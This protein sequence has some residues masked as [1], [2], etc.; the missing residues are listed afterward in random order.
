MVRLRS[1]LLLRVVVR[2]RLHVA[3]IHRPSW[4]VLLIL[5][6]I[7]PPSHILLHILLPCR[8]MTTVHHAGLGKCF[9]TDR[10]L[11]R[12]GSCALRF[13]D[14]AGSQRGLVSGGQSINSSKNKLMNPVTGIVEGLTVAVVGFAVS[15]EQSVVV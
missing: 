12:V 8:Q 7:S 1:E 15:H 13:A 10:V 9:Q 2:V 5:V 4:R 11:R 3:I 14:S 6:V